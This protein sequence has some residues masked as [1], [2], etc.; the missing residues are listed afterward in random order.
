MCVKVGPLNLLYDNNDGA[1]E[2]IAEG[3]GIDLAG[4]NADAVENFVMVVGQ[5]TD[6]RGSS[7]G[8]E[9]N[10]RVQG[11]EVSWKGGGQ[12]HGA[13]RAGGSARP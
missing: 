5:A 11:D 8:R 7:M 6:G 1:I 10:C 2:H 12:G 3:R 9:T 4:S 13:R